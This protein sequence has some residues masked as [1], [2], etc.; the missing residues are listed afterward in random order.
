MENIT[1]TLVSRQ[2]LTEY[3]ME[4]VVSIPPHISFYPGQW[5][6]FVFQE[7][8]ETYERSYTIV[9]HYYTDDSLF[10]EFAISV[11][12]QDKATTHIQQTPI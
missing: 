10:L 6:L 12:I 9:D 3:V 11:A 8:Q 2:M 1:A 4:F 7:K 5:A